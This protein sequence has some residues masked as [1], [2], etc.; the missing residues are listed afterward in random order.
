MKGRDTPSGCVGARP[1]LLFSFSF[2]AHMRDFRLWH[3]WIDSSHT[4]VACGDLVGEECLENAVRGFRRGKRARR[5]PN[6]SQKSLYLTIFPRI[7]SMPTVQL[8]RRCLASASRFGVSM[9]VSSGTAEA[10]NAEF[11]RVGRRQAEPGS[12]A[13]GPFE[14]SATIA[15]FVQVKA[16]HIFE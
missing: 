2:L 13:R 1:Q 10:G 7:L 4:R 14:T 9:R 12:K 8:H 16:V 15:V 6:R 5:R 11:G 3:D